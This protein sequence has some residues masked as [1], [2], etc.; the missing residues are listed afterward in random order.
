MTAE[1]FQAA[2][3]RRFD[4]L[5]KDVAIIRSDVST[6]RRDVIDVKDEVL[7]IRLDA[8]RE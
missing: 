5:D 4:A 7:R 8:A 6:L 2:V 3:I 1:E